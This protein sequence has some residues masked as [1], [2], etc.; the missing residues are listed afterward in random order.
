MPQ[1]PDKTSTPSPS[2]PDLS[3]AMHQSR[4]EP[5][6]QM[7]PL[8]DEPNRD[9]N[10]SLPSEDSEIHAESSDDPINQP[11]D[12]VEQRLEKLR[13]EFRALCKI[14]DSLEQ[15]Y[16][17]IQAAN[18]SELP[19]EEYQ[20]LFQQFRAEHLSKE[21]QKNLL[22]ELNREFDDLSRIKDPIEQ[23]YRLMRQAKA[24]ELAT[25]EYR[26][27]FKDYERRTAEGL[28]GFVNNSLHRLASLAG[29]LGQFTIIVGLILFIAEAGD[30]KRASHTQ[31][32]ETITN[33]K[34]FT[35]SA[36]RIQAIQ[37]LNEGCAYRDIRPDTQNTNATPSLNPIEWFHTQRW[38]E[39]NWRSTPIIGGF[40]PDCISLRGLDIANAHLPEI[41]VS[42]AKLNNARMQ[43]TGLWSANMQG[44]QLRGA[45]FQRAK[46][47]NTNLRGT[48]LEGAQLQNADLSG[49]V[50]GCI[51]DYAMPLCT[52]LN[53]ADLTGVNLRGDQRNEE[54]VFHTMFGHQIWLEDVMFTHA[55]YDD[56]TKIGICHQMNFSEG[57]CTE[58]SYISVSDFMSFDGQFVKDYRCPELLNSICSESDLTQFRQDLKRGL[59]FAYEISPGANLN[60]AILRQAELSDANLSAA[61]LNNADLRGVRLQDAQLAGAELQNADLSCTEPP[62]EKSRNTANCA[63]LHEVNLTE[64]NLSGAN[65]E[66]ANLSEADLT[67][68]SFEN[69]V[70]SGASF[71]DANVSGVNFAGATGWTVE[72]LQAAENWEAAVFDDEQRSQLSPAN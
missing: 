34:T 35:E 64:A 56:G 57:I 9:S 6:G 37:T 47:R 1:L 19:A 67:G 54:T 17:L 49:A 53:R 40:F 55:L 48:D 69:A 22:N 50:L 7:P 31:A 21:H 59:A 68:A 45:Q 20:A 42:W 16:R 14:K 39:I 60:G 36:G 4:E 5:S 71:I 43:D 46:L 11:S 8:L 63:N 70:L 32:W 28:S 18:T 15:N 44:A 38:M 30:R 66:Y 72:Q 3:Q 23:N 29:F 13:D 58:N 2:E 62:V 27:L 33:A 24:S 10:D 51:Y 26:Q 52:N 12:P 65:L 25:E 61:Q 41:N